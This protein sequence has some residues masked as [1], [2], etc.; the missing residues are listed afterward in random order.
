[1]SIAQD[2]AASTGGKIARTVADRGA[3][4]ATPEQNFARIAEAWRMWIRWRYGQDVTPTHADTALDGPAYWMLAV[5]CQIDRH[6]QAQ[7]EAE[8]NAVR[9]QETR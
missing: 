3:V 8:A 7:G 9:S 4:Y 5:G 2:F 1:M 6:V